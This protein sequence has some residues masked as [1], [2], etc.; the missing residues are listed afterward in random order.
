MGFQGDFTRSALGEGR[1]LPVGGLCGIMV[2]NDRSFNSGEP[3]VNMADSP[4]PA[5]PSPRETLLR[6]AFQRFV[7][8]GYHGT[9]MR[10]IARD[11]GM[12]LGNIYNYFASKE[13]LFAA[14]LEAY[15]PYRDILPLLEQ[16]PGEGVEDFVRQA[17]A[18]IVEVLQQR[19]DLLHLLL[20]EIVEFQSRHTAALYQA[21]LPRIEALAQR[22]RDY[23]R[24][25]PLPALTL[26][27]AFI[28]ILWADHLLSQGLGS[29]ASSSLD[30]L[31]SIYLY[32]VMQREAPGEV[33]P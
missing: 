29:A 17:A 9:S 13:A 16:S 20:I 4:S 24:L 11:A 10:Q 32:G 1:A 31:I 30:D 12:A 21:L 28:G 19:P 23:P 14:V 7:R 18:R 6:A 25:R 3:K 2:L 5:L 22:L 33:A 27:R 26:L 15:H 8:Q